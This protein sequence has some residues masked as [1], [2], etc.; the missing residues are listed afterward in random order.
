[1]CSLTH[2]TDLTEPHLCYLGWSEVFILVRKAKAPSGRQEKGG[3]GDNGCHGT[4]EFASQVPEREEGLTSLGA[5]DGQ[6][7]LLQQGH[8]Y[9][10]VHLTIRL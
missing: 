7:C 1:M 6:D 10:S 2:L 4:M 5:E 8:I 9:P 3:E